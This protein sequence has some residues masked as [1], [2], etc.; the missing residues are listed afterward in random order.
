MVFSAAADVAVEVDLTT[1]NILVSTVD[2]D[3]NTTLTDLSTL[4]FLNEAMG[5]IVFKSTGNK[6]VKA[7]IQVD[8]NILSPMIGLS[9]FFV[10]FRFPDFRAV[11]GKTRLSW[12]EGMMFNAGD[13]LFGSQDLNVQATA[14]E[15][16][17]TTAPLASIYIPL[18]RFEFIEAVAIA[19][20]FDPNLI[21]AG[22]QNPNI[23]PF[24]FVKSISGT[25][26]GAR[27]VQKPMGIKTE[28]G[29]LFKGSE[30]DKGAHKP[31]LS[32]QGNLGVDYHLSASTS[33][34]QKALSSQ[35]TNEDFWGNFTHNLTGNSTIS[36]GFFHKQDVSDEG[37]AMTFRLEGL[38]KPTGIW[39]EDNNSSETTPKNYGLMLYPEITFTPEDTVSTLF[40]AIISPIDGSA[41]LTGGLS[42]KVFQGFS[43]LNF[44]SV[45]VGDD[46]DIYQW[47]K[48]KAVT[49]IFGAQYVY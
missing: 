31:Y 14:E 28:V 19:P 25:S 27:L 13:V 9:K 45:T 23:D 48:D 12:G 21:W 17:T 5:N 2:D 39:E 11:F 29:Y 24:N 32:L 15:L 33:F 1:Y 38:V 42:W 43:L 49:A 35:T 18:G 6:N 36:F 10:K 46:N 22:L 8:L 41:Q 16:R 30:A 7:E 26:I 47:N 37:A 34:D 20:Q 40:R 4:Y 44:V 3:G